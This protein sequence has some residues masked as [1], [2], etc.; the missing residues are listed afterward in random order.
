MMKKL[1]LSLALLAITM[2][3]SAQYNQEEMLKEMQKMQEEMMKRFEN[4]EFDFGDSQ[5]FIDTF[6]VKEFDSFGNS[7]PMEPYSGDLTEL[8]EMLQQQMKQMESE[9]WAELEKL[10]ESFGKFSPMIPTPEKLD[11]FK[12]EEG[13]IKE[14][15]N[16]KR[17]SYTL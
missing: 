9:D 7:I 4:L 15:S 14:K 5:L 13:D 1:I 6:F 12:K 8:M 11:E 17:K 10:F 3:L 2:N 16:K